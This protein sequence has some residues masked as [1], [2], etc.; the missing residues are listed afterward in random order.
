MPFCGNDIPSAGE[1]ASDMFSAIYNYYPGLAKVFREEMLPTAQAELA[2][3]Q[4]V[5][6]QFQQLMTDLYKQFGPQLAETGQQIDRSNR[7]A[8][9][10]TDVDILKGSGK[11]LAEAYRDIDQGLNPEYYKVRGDAAGKLSEVLGSINLNDSS[12]EAER[13]INQENIRSGN[14]ATPSATNSELNT[15]RNNL[16][17]AINAASNFLQPASSASAFNPATT[18][19]QRPTSNTGASQFAGV[20]TSAGASAVGAGQNFTNQIGQLQSGYANNM[21]NQRDVVDRINEGFSS[22]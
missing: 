9:A 11:Q 1:S 5:S 15:R 19:L 3:S 2:T 22:L 14:L 10:G 21:A 7:L 16:T 4:A 20:N 13:L 6:P 8:A 17:S 12:P 18:A